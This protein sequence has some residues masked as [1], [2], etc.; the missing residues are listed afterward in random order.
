VSRN[1]RLWLR[2]ALAILML[3][4]MSRV[5]MA[6]GN[7]S[8]ALLSVNRGGLAATSVGNVAIFAGG[9]TDG[10]PVFF[11]VTKDLI[12]VWFCSD[13][14]C[15]RCFACLLACV[16]CLCCSR[17]PFDETS[18]GP[19]GGSSSAVDLYDRQTGQWSTALLSVN[20]GDLAATSVGNVA[21]FAG[22]YADSNPVFFC[23]T[24]DLNFVWFCSDDACLRCFACLLACVCCL[25]CRLPSDET[26]AGPAGYR[27]SSAVDL[28][29]RQTGQW[30]TALLSVSRFSLAATSVGNVAIFAGG[31]TGGGNPVFFCVTKD[32]IFVCLFG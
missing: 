17:L 9:F 19:S 11:C 30:S 8:T 6:Q 2:A 10:N 15:L 22:G 32:L 25:R 3:S 4:S 28:Y 16:C 29:D 1:E 20:R 12:F 21:I 26:P 18:A 31:I 27:S 14:A 13:D 24:K 7:W 23:V 5:S